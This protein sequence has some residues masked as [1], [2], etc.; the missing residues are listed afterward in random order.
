MRRNPR[1]RVDPGPHRTRSGAGHLRLR[2][3]DSGLRR[4][5]PQPRFLGNWQGRGGDHERSPAGPSPTGAKLCCFRDHVYIVDTFGLWKLSFN[6]SQPH[7]DATPTARHSCIQGFASPT[8]A[9]EKLC[10]LTPGAT[11]SKGPPPP[12]EAGRGAA[13]AVPPARLG[14]PP[15]R[16]KPPRQGARLRLWDGEASDET[17][18][19]LLVDSGGRFGRGLH[20]TL[21]TTRPARAALARRSLPP[22]PLRPLPLLP[23]RVFPLLD[24]KSR[25]PLRA[26]GKWGDK[27]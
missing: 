16:A 11:P 17:C 27:N 13:R 20:P 18:A 24:G 23:A 7:R 15:T 6:K 2:A 10:G 14:P 1:G 25:G 5:K 26:G 22:V 19:R 8:R 12:S 21:P 4:S 9:G 3:P